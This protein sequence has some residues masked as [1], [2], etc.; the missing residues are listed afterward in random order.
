[1]RSTYRFPD[2]TLGRASVRRRRAARP[3]VVL[4]PDFTRT[5]PWS[6]RG[7]VAG[8]GL[9]SAIEPSRRACVGL[10]A[11]ESTTFPFPFAFPAPRTAESWDNL[12][13]AAAWGGTRHSTDL[14][15]RARL[16]VPE[17]WNGELGFRDGCAAL[18]VLIAWHTAHNTGRAGG[19]AQLRG[20]VPDNLKWSPF[21]GQ[22]FLRLDIVLLRGGT[23]ICVGSV[24]QTEPQVRP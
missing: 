20:P 2:P 6:R 13:L 1:M 14:R 10:P 18:R 15:R 24:L 11:S 16:C 17:A 5:V 3:P 12:P 19:L 7:R 8:L 21:A 4:N 22:L 23:R 9:A